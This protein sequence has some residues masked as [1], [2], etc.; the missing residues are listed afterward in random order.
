MAS[1][2]NARR[3]DWKRAGLARNR[4]GA[5]LSRRS[6]LA[7][8]AAGAAAGAFGRFAPGGIGTPTARAQDVQPGGTL[9]YGLSFD[10]DGTLDPQVT[11]YDSSI[12][13][14]LNVCEPLLWMATATDFYPALAESWEVSDD[15]LTYTFHLKKDVKFHDGTPFNADAV[16]F[17]YDRVVEGRN[18]TAQG[19][20]VDPKKVI[21]PGQ[22]FNQIDAYDHAEIVDDYTI[23]LILSRPFGGFLT[24]LNGYLGIVSPTAVEKMGLADFGRKPVGTGPFM[25]QEWVDAD[26]VTLVKNPD[27]NW[28]SSFFK[29]SGAAYLDQIIYKII[30]DN[31]VRTGTL[32]SGESQYVDNVDALQLADLQENPDLAIIQQG[33]PGSGDILL[34]NLAR[35][36]SPQADIAVRRALSYAIDK[37]AFNQA[38]FGGIYSPAA[39]PLM[40]PT[41]GY[42]P[43]TEEL[44]GYDPAKA[45]SM[46]DE[47]GWTLNGEIREKAGK[48]LAFYWPIQDRPDDKAMA[49]FIQGAFRAV[50]ADVTVEPMEH[51][52][53]EEKTRTAG[54][55]DLAFMW[56]SYADPDTLRTIFYSGNIGNFNVGKYNDPEMDKMLLDAAASNDPEERQ[57]LYSKIQLKVLDEAV[58]IPLDDTITYNGKQASL[59][60]DFLDFLASYVWMNDAHFTQ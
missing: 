11:N 35:T 38:A 39:S 45:A 3:G 6:L 46:L 53:F 10:F 33:Q 40:K 21:V 25:I 41:F 58:T 18:L 30:P 22:S 31:A 28:G 57:A 7:G 27:Y 48:K 54:D 19:K 47:A 20:E 12:R 2:W 56:F 26:H 5:A 51:G 17:T 4:R 37:D 16:K 52:A 15:G 9:T 8:T 13:V 60:G 43:K 14:M 29:H 42:E 49:T 50:G 36:D 59:E 32:L 34:F 24:G 44:Y 55:Y 1:E 23:K